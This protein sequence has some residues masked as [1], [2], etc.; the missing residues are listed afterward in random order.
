MI[1]V[2]YIAQPASRTTLDAIERIAKSADVEAMDVAAAYITSGGVAD[3]VKRTSASLGGAWNGIKKRWIT[4]FDYCRTDP[5]ALDVLLSIPSSSVRIHDAQFCLEHGGWPKVPFHPKAFLFRSNLRDYVLTGSGNVSR[6][7]LSRGIEA[8]LALDVNRIGPN[9]PTSSVAVN[10][11]RAWFSTSW[12]NATPL[13]ALLLARYGKLCESVPN[14]K[15]PVPTEDDL[16]SSDIGSG[17]LS[18]KDL[19]K[20]RVCRHFWTEAGN[21]TKN[22]GPHLPGN[23]LMMKR[24]TRVFFGFNQ[25]AVSENTVLGAVDMYFDTGATGQ[26]TLS[27][28][29]NKMDKLNLPMPG[30]DGPPSYDN[31]CLLFRRMTPGVIKLTLGTKADRATWLKRSRDIDGA[32]KMTSGREWG[33]F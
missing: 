2:D 7:G 14:L 16:A 6:S 27:Y 4:S 8:G 20:L 13:N 5:V 30:S 15:S 12:K 24:L 21:I 32:F 26:Y 31:Q 23:Q 28:S 22:R 1:Q 19:Q 11:L 9:E 33:V 17:A 29:D 18:G 3:L 25:T 10:E